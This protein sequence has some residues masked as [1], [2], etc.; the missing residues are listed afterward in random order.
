MWLIWTHIV[1]ITLPFLIINIFAFSLDWSKWRSLFRETKFDVWFLGFISYH[2]LNSKKV[3]IN[4]YW[5]IHLLSLRLS[6]H[7]N[8][9]KFI[10]AQLFNNILCFSYWCYIQI[11][12]RNTD[13][14]IIQIY[15]RN[16]YLIFLFF[17]FN[18]FLSYLY[19]LITFFR[20]LFNPFV[21]LAH[22]YALKLLMINI[23]LFLFINFGHFYT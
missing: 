4:L 20:L 12:Y 18:I 2:G 16:T 7:R 6:N 22:N 1:L 17:L 10:Y 11:G 23:R 14:Y 8:L 19:N 21:Q 9:A 5:Q 3:L 13:W 15:Y